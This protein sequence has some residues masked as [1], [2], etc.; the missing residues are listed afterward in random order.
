MNK[1]TKDEQLNIDEI[2]V[3]KIL[4]RIGESRQRRISLMS[5]YSLGKVNQLVNQLKIKEYVSSEG[6]LTSKGRDYLNYH[7]PKQA[8]ILAAGYGLRM[9][10]IN[11]EEPKGLLE[12]HGEP[13]IERII[14]QLHEVGITNIKIVVG[15]MKE[16]YEYLIDEYN[17]DL[18]V[19]PYYSTRNN[20]DCQEV[21]VNN[22]SR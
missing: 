11:T 2:T 12:V 8:T 3:L 5:N 18:I 4:L 16:H 21:C 13:L 10:P 20:R 14:K 22:L 15:F 9:V 17:V 1:I 7:H 6:T 19:N